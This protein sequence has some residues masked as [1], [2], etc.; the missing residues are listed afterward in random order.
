MLKHVIE[1]SYNKLSYL[2]QQEGCVNSQLNSENMRAFTFSR[3]NVVRNDV[4]Y[5]IVSIVQY[6]FHIIV[7]REN[8]SY[9][10]HLH[11]VHSG[12]IV[13]VVLVV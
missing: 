13:V 2:K 6:D 8:V 10:N 1:L 7:S 4:S 3:Y 9:D 5:D 12:C 11:F